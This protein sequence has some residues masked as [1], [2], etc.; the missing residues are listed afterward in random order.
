MSQRE[1]PKWF[2]SRSDLASDYL[3]RI[4][5]RAEKTH[6]APLARKAGDSQ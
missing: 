5:T 2:N 3:N 6:A 4:G 1:A